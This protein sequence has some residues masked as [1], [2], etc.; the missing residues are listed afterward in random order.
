MQIISLK[1][2]IKFGLTYLVEVSVFGA[3]ATKINTYI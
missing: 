2:G 1:K 3:H